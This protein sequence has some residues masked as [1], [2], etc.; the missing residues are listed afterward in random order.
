MDVITP[1]PVKK[2]AP[3]N[4]TE[5]LSATG[6][7]MKTKAV[8][9]SQSEKLAKAEAFKTAL[10]IAGKKADLIPFGDEAFILNLDDSTTAQALAYKYTKLVSEVM[11][12]EG[13]PIIYIKRYGHI[14]CLQFGDVQQ[15]DAKTPVAAMT[16]LTSSGYSN[17][18]QG[19]T[20][21]RAVLNIAEKGPE[22][23]T[24]SPPDDE[25][26]E[27]E[28]Q[29]ASSSDKEEEEEIKVQRTSSPPSNL[30]ESMIDA[31]KNPTPK[32]PTKRKRTDLEEEADS[33]IAGSGSE[34]APTKKA[35]LDTMLKITYQRQKMDQIMKKLKDALPLEEFMSCIRGDERYY[36][37]PEDT[38]DRILELRK[39]YID[40]LPHW[41]HI[42]IKYAVVQDAFTTKNPHV[43]TKEDNLSDFTLPFKL[44]IDPDDEVRPYRLRPVNRL[45][46]NSDKKLDYIYA[47]YKVESQYKHMN[48]DGT[49][50]IETRIIWIYTLTTLL[51][52]TETKEVTKTPIGMFWVFHHPF[53]TTDSK[54]ALLVNMFASASHGDDLYRAIIYDPAIKSTKRTLEL[55]HE[56]YKFKSDED[57]MFNTRILI[58]NGIYDWVK[59]LSSLTK[60]PLDTYDY[61]SPMS[62]MMCHAFVR[63]VEHIWAFKYNLKP[64]ATGE[65]GADDMSIETPELSFRD[66]MIMNA[67]KIVDP[68]DIPGDRTEDICFEY[69]LAVL[70]AAKGMPLPHISEIEGQYNSVVHVNHVFAQFG[71]TPNRI[72]VPEMTDKNRKSFKASFLG[73]GALKPVEQ[74]SWTYMETTGAGGELHCCIARVRPDALEIYGLDTASVVISYDD[75][76]K[77]GKGARHRVDFS[78]NGRLYGIHSAKTLNL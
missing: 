3:K 24:S 70:F 28:E 75:F 12:I 36:V 8:P 56:H 35:K 50:K 39:E 16:A 53:G 57:S 26:I 59:M 37:F 72:I 66:F 9:E 4:P 34:D 49:W 27:V 19:L 38:E 51:T 42:K 2:S 74:D 1:K 29:D 13:C 22:T 6:I 31:I 78:Y 54:K 58:G 44:E 65:R 62:N 47:R 18:I 46:R 10:G 60:T 76:I 48:I 40:D 7:P 69:C 73:S 21:A 63:I 33:Y 64:M 17:I 41:W 55:V 71:I 25:E 61:I 43:S 32:S 52:D 77:S 23:K 45:R 5:F 14:F 15:Y 20:K 30:K 67:G 11:K 68:D